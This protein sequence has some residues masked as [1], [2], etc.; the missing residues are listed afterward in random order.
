MTELGGYAGAVKFF[1]SDATQYLKISDYT[2][3]IFSWSLTA[4]AEE[5]AQAVPARMAHA[6]G[7]GF[8]GGTA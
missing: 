3:N 5:R 7:R 2:H 8:S 6:R 1:V 4:T